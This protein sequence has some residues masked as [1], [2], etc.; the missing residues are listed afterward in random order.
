MAFGGVIGAGICLGIASALGRPCLQ[1]MP[2]KA[3]FL[4][5]FF[6]WHTN[7]YSLY[8]NPITVSEYLCSGLCRS[9]YLYIFYVCGTQLLQT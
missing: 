9:D 5:V 6:G 1:G 7:G 8:W 4:T 3:Y 2:P